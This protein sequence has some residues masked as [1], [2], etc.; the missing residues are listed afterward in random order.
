VTSTDLDV[1]SSV[2]IERCLSI[3]SKDCTEVVWKDKLSE[4]TG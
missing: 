2:V 4:L 3:D 1:A